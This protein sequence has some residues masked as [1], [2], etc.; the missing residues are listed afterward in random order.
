MQLLWGPRRT[1]GLALA[2]DGVL[3][4]A[5]LAL[6]SQRV[7]LDRWPAVL[8]YA[9]LAALEWHRGYWEGLPRS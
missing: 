6:L 1:R 9:A 2:V 7:P 3:V 5:G 8:D 4:A